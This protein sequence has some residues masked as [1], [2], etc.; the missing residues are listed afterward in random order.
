MDFLRN[1]EIE[2]EDLNASIL[3]SG[4]WGAPHIS[5]PATL[6]YS[7]AE[8]RSIRIKPEAEPLM[9]H[10]KAYFQFSEPRRIRAAERNLADS[11]G[12]FKSDLRSQ[13]KCGKKPDAF[14]TGGDV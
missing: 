14:L 11:T 13:S 10:V 3:Y 12:S 9:P 7:K 1:D 8:T 4:S 5:D 6:R 2:G